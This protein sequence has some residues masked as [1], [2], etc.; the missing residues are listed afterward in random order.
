MSRKTR[1]I[2]RDKSTGQF[3]SIRADLQRGAGRFGSGQNKHNLQVFGSGSIQNWELVIT[4]SE[5][6]KQV[7][8]SDSEAEIPGEEIAEGK[9]RGSQTGNPEQREK[10]SR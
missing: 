4:G 9:M 6:V 8:V 7:R 10:R 3:P 2:I 1:E 5:Q